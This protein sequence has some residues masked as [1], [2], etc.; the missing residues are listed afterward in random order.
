MVWKEVEAWGNETI[1][2]MFSQEL[3]LGRMSRK[4]ENQ[5]F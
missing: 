1:Y 4:A 2:A 3:F 5:A